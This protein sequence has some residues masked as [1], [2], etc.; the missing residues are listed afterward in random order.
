VTHFIFPCMFG[1]HL[2]ARRIYA[3]MAVTKPFWNWAAKKG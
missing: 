3:E 1:R 2:T